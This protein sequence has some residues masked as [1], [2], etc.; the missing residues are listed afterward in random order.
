MISIQGLERRTIREKQVLVA[1]RL[2]DVRIQE[3][4][5]GF[6]KEAIDRVVSV[7]RLMCQP[8]LVEDHSSGITARSPAFLEPK[9]PQTP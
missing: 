8:E 6:K 1:R 4:V 7:D 3:I 5:M 9:A 2:V